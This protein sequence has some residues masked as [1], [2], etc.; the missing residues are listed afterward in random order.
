MM[1]QMR[2]NTKIILW[3]VVVAFVIT[4]FAV[5][6][7]DLQ[8]GGM[9]GTGTTNVIGKVNGVS[10]TGQQYN[11]MYQQLAAQY[12]NQ[13]PD[14]TIGAQLQDAISAQTWDNLV[15]GILTSQKIE[16]LN[17]TA[18]D[19][20]VV[21]FLTNTPPPEAQR[22]FVNEQG[23]FDYQAYLT[24]LRNPEN[25]WTSFEQ[26]ARQR[27]PMFK[28]NQ[29]LASQV[30]VSD[31]EVRQRYEASNVTM[32]VAYVEFPIASED[33]GD[34]TPGEDDIT[35]YYDNHID[36]YMEGEKASIEFL[37]IPLEASAQDIEDVELTAADIHKEIVERGEDFGE[38]AK[39]YSELP[40]AQVGG[41][42]GLITRTMRDTAIM[43]AV[44]SMTPGQVS[45][46]ISVE[47][48]VYIVKLIDKAVEDD[49]QK[50][51]IG[52]I[53][54]G[55]SPSGITTDSLH[56]LANEVQAAAKAD[57]LEVAAERFGL[58]MKSS[59]PFLQ[60]FPIGAL[61]F[62]PSISRFAFANE[63]GTISGVLRND[64]NY[65][66]VRVKDRLADAPRPLDAVRGQVEFALRYERQKNLASR[67]ATA[68]RTAVSTTS[69]DDAVKKY[70]YQANKPAPFKANER[71]GSV[72]ANSPFMF[73]LLNTETSRITPPIESGGNLYVA[74]VIA[75][76]PIDEEHFKTEAPAIHAQITSTKTQ[77]FMTFW[78]DQLLASADVQDNRDQLQIQ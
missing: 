57:G 4:I 50:F 32:E 63:P 61:G 44:A 27:I 48:G 54:I 19:Q 12:R 5:W 69:W 9:S 72:A 18:T 37:Q 35:T 28:L 7:L 67:K 3:I 23:Q 33:L 58:D 25:D 74:Q 21:D 8:G 60:N 64:D 24:A 30:H 47:N 26:L 65:F 34:W 13:S 42:T 68:F 76:E 43:D 40:T 46:P 10:I 70:G 6:G 53:F 78:Y 36:E 14:G 55:F 62:V 2:E 75:R 51:N 49:V 73:A 39:I 52:E 38:T 20:E 59:M 1:Q 16:E 56:T 17:I 29:Y 45:A 22:Y 11:A 66:V 71:A 77:E 41:E 31:T 15:L